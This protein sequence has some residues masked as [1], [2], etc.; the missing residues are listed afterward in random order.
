MRDYTMIGKLD[1]KLEITNRCGRCFFAFYYLNSVVSVFT[2]KD[3]FIW[4]TTRVMTLMVRLAFIFALTGFL[5]SST[6]VNTLDLDQGVG[7]DLY[8]RSFF[9]GIVVVTLVGLLRMF[10]IFAINFCI[11]KTKCKSGLCSVNK[12]KVE[13]VRGD[14]SINFD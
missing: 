2:A 8:L 4:A 1:R 11:R 14:I 3:R 7:S 9:I 12:E 13:S 5:F 6:V 10:G